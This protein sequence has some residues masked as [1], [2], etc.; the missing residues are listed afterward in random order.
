MKNQ[1]KTDV[2]GYHSRMETL[3]S[4]TNE[5]LLQTETDSQAVKA[6]LPITGESFQVGRDELGS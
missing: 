2:I 5:S 1:R 4:D 6:N 3:N